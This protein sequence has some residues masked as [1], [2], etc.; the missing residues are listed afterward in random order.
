LNC[1]TLNCVVKWAAL[2]LCI[3]E[4]LVRNVGPKTIYPDLPFLFM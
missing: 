4:V 1:F 2:V 3:L